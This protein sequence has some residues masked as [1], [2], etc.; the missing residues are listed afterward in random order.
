MTAI[1]NSGSPVRG[2]QQ[3]SRLASPAGT[4]ETRSTIIAVD[5]GAILDEVQNHG[6]P[7]YRV[8]G[9]GRLWLRTLTSPPTA[10]VAGDLWLE[11]T[12]DG[13]VL[14]YKGTDGERTLI[15]AQASGVLVTAATALLTGHAVRATASGLLYSAATV[16][17]HHV[18][19]VIAETVMSGDSARLLVSGDVLDLPDWSLLT[20]VALLS[21][22]VR[23]WL[24]A[25][26]GRYSTTAPQSVASQIGVG[27]TPTSLLVMNPPPIIA[28]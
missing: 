17:Q 1:S 15:G 26:P 8:R 14:R 18:A 2:I 19:G 10:P 11:D 12:I 7:V 6:V 27:L 5:D 9:D 13:T 3:L 21:P 25:T 16:G 22:G 28:W 23:Y 24:S 20:G 4:A